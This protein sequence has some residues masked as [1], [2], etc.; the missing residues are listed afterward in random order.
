MERD[1]NWDIREQVLFLKAEIL[2]LRESLPD[3]QTIILHYHLTDDGVLL[4]LILVNMKN[5]THFFYSMEQRKV[6]FCF[7][8]IKD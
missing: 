8:H 1:Q 3:T 7:K 5:D 4:E 2:E 6:G